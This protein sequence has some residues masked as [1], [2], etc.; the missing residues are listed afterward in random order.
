MVETVLETERLLLCTWDEA[1]IDEH[2]AHLNTPAVMRWL[3]PPR[4][5]DEIVE[6]FARLNATQAEQGFSFWQIRLKRDGGLLGY[7]G[8][9]RVNAE[10][11]SL[12]GEFE[13]GWGLREDAWGQGYACEAASAAL[14]RAFSVHGALQVVAFTVAGN[15]G[16]W[17]LMERLGM[18]RR[19]ELDFDDPAFD[20]DLNPTI[21][22]SIAR[23][24]WTA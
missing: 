8:L 5:R 14:D 2:I 9:K 3:G 13:I 20:A 19:A 17:R 16:S 23:D 1:L 10:G 18:R 22:Y 4:S 15:T 7:C 12:T 24:Q 21:V 11:T 6:M